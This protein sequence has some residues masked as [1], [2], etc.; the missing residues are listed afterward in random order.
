M[1]F[2][3]SGRVIENSLRWVSS[4]NNLDLLERGF[5]G[6]QWRGQAGVNQQQIDG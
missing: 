6:V 3:A 2:S 1:N 4:H 5:L